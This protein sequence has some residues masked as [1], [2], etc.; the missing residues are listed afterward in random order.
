MSKDR[1]AKQIINSVP[2]GKRGEDQWRASVKT[3]KVQNQT[4]KDA[5]DGEED[6]DRWEEMRCLMCT[7][8]TKV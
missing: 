7:G 8:R 6:R 2:G 1:R 4:R 5:L 3:S